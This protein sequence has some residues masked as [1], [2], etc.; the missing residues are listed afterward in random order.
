[1]STD[2]TQIVWFLLPKDICKQLPIN[3]KVESF[4]KGEKLTS[5][6]RLSYTNIFH[7]SVENYDGSRLLYTQKPHTLR[8]Q[9][10]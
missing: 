2:S 1:M 9:E 8:F 3:F 5:T 10:F 6:F 7:F 4:L